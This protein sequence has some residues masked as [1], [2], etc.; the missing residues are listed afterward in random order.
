MEII[1]LTFLKR[2]QHPHNIKRRKS[3]TLRMIRGMWAV[4]SGPENVRIREIPRRKEEKI[5]GVDGEECNA[6]NN[7][8][9]LCS[10]EFTE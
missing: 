9:P 7:V 4:V 1:A 2:Q 3:F 10:R 6:G 5:G 8:N